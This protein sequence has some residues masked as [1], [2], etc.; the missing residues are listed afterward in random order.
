VLVAPSDSGIYQEFSESFRQNLRALCRDRPDLA[1]CSAENPVLLRTI[2]DLDDLAGTDVGQ[3]LIPLGT[4]AAD[5]V[6]ARA[7]GRAMLFT[8]IPRSAYDKL[9]DCCPDGNKLPMSA[10]FVEQP[11]K[12]KLQLIATMLPGVQR[13]GVLLGPASEM[14]AED[15]YRIGSALGLEIR[16]ASV[17]ETAE[18]GPGLGQLLGE[19]EVLLAIAD[20]VVYNSTTISNILLATYRHHIPLIGYSEALVKAGATAAVFARIEQLAESAAIAAL[21][22]CDRQTLPAPGF[23]SDFSVRVNRDVLRSLG[24]PMQSEE[25]LKQSLQERGP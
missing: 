8:L 15:L 7:G 2:G 11:L 22:Y 25:I 20:P 9:P 6:T 18:V 3:L 14:H 12:R 5:Y 16:V 23:A 17:K 24:L 10:V 21:E 13:V 19:V 4:E 1:V